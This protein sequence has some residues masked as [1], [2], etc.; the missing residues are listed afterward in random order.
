MSPSESP[1]PM[2]PRRIGRVLWRRKLV[3]SVVAA[4]VLLAGAGLLFTRQ[5]IYE[6]T[7]SVALLPASTNS[8][9]LPNYPNLI[10]SLIP[11]Y[12]QLVSSPVL[13]NQ[14]ASTLPFA[15]SETQLA[16]DVHAE[17]LSSAAVIT[18][19]AERPNPVQA[20]ELAARTTA[21]FLTE[22]QGNGVVI[23]HIYGQPTVPDAP[24]SPKVKLVLGAIVTMAL[25]LGLAAGLAWDRL[26]GDAGVGQP[27]DP[28]L[29]PVLGTIPELDD[30]LEIAVLLA[31]KAGRSADRSLR[32]SFL[33]STGHLMRSVAVTS[34]APGQ[35]KTTVAVS[36]A[37]SL[38]EVGLT[39]ALV[40]AQVRCPALHELFGL[41]NR[42]GLT[43]TMLSGAEP[44]ALLHPVPAIPGLQVVAAGPALAG[45]RAEARLYREQ[46]PRF[47][48]LVDLVIV[49]SPALQDGPGA[50]L[51]AGVTDGVVLVV[52]SGTAGLEHLEA[53]LRI[54]APS[55]TPVLGTVLTGASRLVTRGDPGRDLDNHRAPGA[56]A[57]TAPTAPTAQPQAQ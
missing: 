50:A 14:V 32:T 27:V 19:V 10:S 52:P 18:I 37:A 13:L 35:S 56:T 7:S 12:V 34:L 1:D 51:P 46:L 30:Q 15:V 42:Q 33:R 4:V 49:D 31:R 8:S 24:A 57:P 26:F 25:I 11:T 36:L 54:L 38:V 29:V 41:D 48:S 55:G 44:A 16:N 21:V 43:S 17:S 20:E 45:P 6:A 39:V 3:C 53:A 47:T 2:T 40:D 9:V 28:A 5:K 23:P 22:L